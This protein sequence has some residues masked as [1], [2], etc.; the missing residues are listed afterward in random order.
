MDRHS[1]SPFGSL[2]DEMREAREH[3]PAPPR[4]PR[5]RPAAP[6]PVRP[7]GA[8][9][10]DLVLESGVVSGGRAR[11]AGSWRWVPSVVLHAAALIAVVAVPLFLADELPSP[12]AAV[13]KVFFMPSVLAPPLPPPPAPRAVAPAA[14]RKDAAPSRTPSLAAPVV[15][16]ATIRPEEIAAPAPPLPVHVASADEG[17][18]GG[19]EEGVPGGIVGGIIEKAEK[20]PA[21]RTHARA[22]VDVKEPRK[23]KNVAPVYPD[24]AARG[25]IEGVVLLEVSIRPDGKVDDVRVL[26]SIPLLDAAAVDAARQWVFTP[27]LLGGVPVSVTMTVS[28]RFNLRDGLAA[29]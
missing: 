23:V 7:E 26:R 9:E 18:P 19:V 27:T 4:P 13:G 6:R 28:V 25:K 12:A 29:S 22:G 10:P 21:P 2:L 11:A 16:P 14:P 3:S 5:P 15:A 17:V 8:P 24:V 20:E 1:V